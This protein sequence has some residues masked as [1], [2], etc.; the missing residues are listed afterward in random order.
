[1]ESTTTPKLGDEFAEA[2]CYAAKL[3]ATQTRKGGDIPY[4]GHLMSVSALVI[5]AGGSQTQAIAGLLHD[6]VEDQGGKPTLD[7]IES[8]FG[9]TVAK[10][11][12]EC[13]DTDEIPKPPWRDRKERYIAHLRGASDEAVLVS[14]AD[15]VDNARA[16]LRDLRLHGDHLWQR[17]NVKDPQ[18]HLWYYRGL[19]E[20]FEERTDSW[21]VDELRYTVEQIAALAGPTVRT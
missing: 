15:K 7:E 16:I 18:Q 1:M 3:H 12:S 11:V 14:L 20:V 8:R 6:A 19:L 21:L 2:M 5:E 13:S 10:I 9:S 17:F 4:F